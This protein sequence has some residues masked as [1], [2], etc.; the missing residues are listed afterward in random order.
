MIK[1]LTNHPYAQCKIIINDNSI[2][3]QS[4]NTIVAT[5]NNGWL[6]INGLYS[7][8]TR[9]HIGEFVKEYANINYQIAKRLYGDGFKYNIYTGELRPV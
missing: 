5:I 8:T 6:V 4:Y 3:C 2:A 7:A 9:R 1:T